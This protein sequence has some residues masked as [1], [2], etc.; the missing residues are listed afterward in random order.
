MLTILQA[1]LQ[2]YVNWE[3]P[4][5]QVG[6][7]SRGNRDQNDNIHWIIQKAREFQKNLW[8]V[9]LLIHWLHALFTTVKPLTLWV[10]TNWK[11]LSSMGIPNRLTCL[12]RN[13]YSGWEAKVRTGHGKMACFKIEKG[14]Y[15]DCILSLCLLNSYAEYI[16]QNVMLDK[17]Q[18]TSASGYD[19]RHVHP[20]G[21]TPC[22]RSGAA[23]ESGRLWWCRNGWEEPPCV[24]GQGRGRDEPLRARG[25]GQWP[26]R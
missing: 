14:V 22:P 26:G 16:M 5:V 25:Q 7:K 9:L 19:G 1:R 12:L 4:D 23:A 10:T 8:N 20:R 24:R 2:H 15:Q 17:S 3:Y 11:N 6:F 21:A 18:A 13:L